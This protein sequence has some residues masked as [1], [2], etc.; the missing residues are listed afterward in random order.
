MIGHRRSRCSPDDSNVQSCRSATTKMIG[1]WWSIIN[2]QDYLKA[3]IKMIWRWRLRRS[4]V[5][6][7]IDHHGWSWNWLTFVVNGHQWLLIKDC[8]FFSK[9][10]DVKYIYIPNPWVWFL[11]PGILFQLSKHEF[12]FK[13]QT[14]LI[15]NSLAKQRLRLFIL[16]STISLIILCHIK[17]W[18]CPW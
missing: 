3:K 12:G 15:L 1:H 4:I 14:P 6:T 18:C 10:Y 7:V 11:N 16:S 2:G 5:M 17:L 8:Q 13:C 9:T